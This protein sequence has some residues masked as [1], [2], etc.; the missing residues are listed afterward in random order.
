MPPP[1]NASPVQSQFRI[2]INDRDVSRD[3]APFLHRLSVRDAAGAHLDSAEIQ[4]DDAGVPFALPRPGASG[5]RIDLRGPR[6]S[7]PDLV[8]T[9]TV[10]SVRS[11]GNRSSGRLLTVSAKSA[12]LFGPVKE[13]QERHF[14]EVSIGEAFSAAAQSV[15]LSAHVDAD[16]AALHREYLA[17]EGE[18]FL[19]FGQRLAQEIGATFKIAGGRAVLLKRNGGVT[20][21]G[22]ELPLIIAEYGHNLLGWSI[23]PVR[24]RPRHARAAVR[25]YDQQAASWRTHEVETG[26][27]G[28]SALLVALHPAAD[29]DQAAAGAVG[30]AG[31]VSRQAGGGEVTID[32][33]TSAK[34]EAMCRVVGAR[35]GIDGEYRI[36]SVEHLLD[37]SSGL[38]TRLELGQPQGRAGHDGRKSRQQLR[39]RS[40]EE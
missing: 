20:A 3:V 31:E 18:S 28:S 38:T 34:P 11:E 32:G 6:E 23:E 8:F 39:T 15:G 36:A 12:D 2:F 19:A 9:G 37:R 40:F 29:A 26:V 5:L 30:L 16:L 33:D 13:R 1:R 35:A 24:A 22:R 27:E 17:M 21:S 7:G 14:D 25:R 10:D 4:L